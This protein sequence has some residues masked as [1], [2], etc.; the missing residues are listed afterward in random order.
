MQRMSPEQRE[1][2][3]RRGTM[4][5][6]ATV[7]IDNGT[8]DWAALDERIVPYCR[9]YEK[10]KIEL[11]PDVLRSEFEVHGQGWVGHLDRVY[12]LGGRRVLCDIKTNEVDEATAIQTAA[13][14]KGV[15]GTVA[16]MGLALK[17]NGDYKV[18][19][20]ERDARDIAGWESALGV[21]QWKV[22]AGLVKATAA[23]ETEQE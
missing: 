23:E 13:Y 20:F 11:S 5:H 19:W 4:I 8:L 7:L 10:F 14:S 1:W 17:D 6:K 3:F 15:R 2:Y 22:M 12:C 9:A 16:R 21:A 18:T